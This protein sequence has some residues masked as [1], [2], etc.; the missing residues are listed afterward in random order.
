[1]PFQFVKECWAQISKCRDKSFRRS[2]VAVIN[3]ARNKVF[4][5][6]LCFRKNVPC[7]TYQS[8]SAPKLQPLFHAYEVNI[9][10][11]DCVFQS[12]SCCQ[13]LEVASTDSWR[14]RDGDYQFRSFQSCEAAHFWE[15]KIIA[16]AKPY[17]SQRRVKC[18]CLIAWAEIPFFFENTVCGK[19]HFAVFA[20]YSFW[21]HEDCS[22]E[23]CGFCFFA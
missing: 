3:F 5:I 16:Y 7:W 19:V 11:K 2:H 1:M 23:Y 13:Y 22:V 18:G 6:I 10:E 4:F 20:D 15:E 8:A 14:S 17:V 21:S 9:R 12:S